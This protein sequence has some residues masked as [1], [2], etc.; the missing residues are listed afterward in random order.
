LW[1]ED[2]ALE[3][4]QTIG[5]CGQAR[6]TGAAIQTSLMLHAAFRL[7]LRQI[8]GLRYKLALHGIIRHL[9]RRREWQMQRFT[10]PKQAQRFLP[11]HSRIHD[12]FQRH[13]YRIAAN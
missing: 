3:C 1:I 8:E 7:R 13:R 11:T 12:H 10:F 4:W 6:Y 5:P 2:A 9:P